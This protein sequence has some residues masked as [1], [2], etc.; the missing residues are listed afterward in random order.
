[1][2]MLRLA[3]A[4]EILGAPLH[5]SDAAFDSVSTDTRTLQPGA[6][7]VALQGPHFD[8]HAFIDTARDKGAVGALVSLPQPLELPWIQVEDTRLA[9]GRLAAAWRE[10]K[11]VPL[12]A[13]TG[14]NGKTTVKEML[15]AILQQQGAVLATRGN[16]NNDIGMP[17]TLLGL[18]DERFAVLE[19]GA[20]HPGEIAYLTHIAAPDVALIT[21]AGAAHL[22]GF[23]D[24]NGVARAKGEILAGLTAAGTAVLNA[25]DPYLSYWLGQ[26]QG[27][28][29][30][31]F[32]FAP[33]AEV[34]ADPAAVEAH[35]TEQGFQTRVPVFTPQ[36]EFLLELPLGGLHNLRNALAA[37]AAGLAL[38]LSLTDIQR[39]LASVQPV[40]GRLQ[41]SLSPS[42]V[43]VID[44]S[45]NA[46]PDS[47]GAAIEVLQRAPGRRWL[48]MG[49]LAE[50]GESATGLHR[51]IG[52]RARSAGIERLWCCG[53]LS[54]AAVDAFGP[55]GR[56]FADRSEL[57]LALR[58]ELAA[59]DTVLVKGSR[60]AGMEQVV[61]VLLER[62]ED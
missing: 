19:L 43:R 20:N 7:F 57:V 35:W 24:L 55:Q 8:G 53:P 38:H 34:R 58:P 11:A 50:L 51:G 39:G 16:L 40:A 31:T 33:G 14:S 27:R 59:G 4:G 6:L 44:D 17:L 1:M 23:G 10:R 18:R 61:A 15:A 32:G 22:E 60:S 62:G 41:T 9:L 13:V 54:R 52:E 29:V 30:L 5:G 12:V 36:G 37:C 47:M 21:N 48:V 3:Q 25:D 49:D 42:G 28:Q 46:N 45:Y 56:H 2:S 26:V